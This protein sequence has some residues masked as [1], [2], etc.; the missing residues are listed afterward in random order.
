MPALPWGLAPFC[1]SEG[2]KEEESGSPH[3]TISA[4][5]NLDLRPAKGRRKSAVTTFDP[6][7]LDLRPAKGRRKSAVTIFDPVLIEAR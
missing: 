5:V 6:V 1:P 3:W 2:V 4:T 7:N